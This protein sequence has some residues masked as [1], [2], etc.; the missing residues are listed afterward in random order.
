M[1]LL[2]VGSEDPG[3]RLAAYNLLYSLS[4]SFR[5][6]IGNQ[7]LNAKGLFQTIH[8]ISFTNL[9]LHISDLCIPSNSSDFIVNI[10]E[11]LAKS[12]LHLTLE[13]LN[14]AFVGFAKSNEPMRQLSLDYMVPWLRNL[15]VFT[16]HSPDDHKKNMSKT[17][18]VIRLLID[19][20]VKRVEVRNFV[21]PT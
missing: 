2:N 14:E 10:S 17:K 1:A 4:L 12:E 7:L 9:S 21:G 13:F 18:D 20:T 16:R 5:F 15:A 11:S 8:S 6:D 3:L 19:V